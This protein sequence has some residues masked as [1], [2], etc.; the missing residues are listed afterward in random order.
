MLQVLS[1]I[2]NYPRRTAASRASPAHRPPA[3]TS[4]PSERSARRVGEACARSVGRA[5]DEQGAS[6]QQLEK[7]HE[8]NMMHVR[9]LRRASERAAS[10]R[11][12]HPG[13]L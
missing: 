2:K 7:E 1:V 13:R 8:K 6:P 4:L 9:L 3:T 10:T 5:R 12:F 11:P